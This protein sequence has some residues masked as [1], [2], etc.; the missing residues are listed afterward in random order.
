MVLEA[1]RAEVLG[2]RAWIGIADGALSF[3]EP[4]RRLARIR[5]QEPTGAER[6]AA[7]LRAAARIRIAVRAVALRNA[8]GKTAFEGQ[9][10]LAVTVLEAAR[11]RLRAR[12]RRA[13]R[14]DVLWI[15]SL[16]TARLRL[17]DLTAS[18]GEAA[19]PR[20]VRTR[21]RYAIAPCPSGLSPVGDTTKRRE[22]RAGPILETACFR[23]GTG[24]GA[25][26][27][28]S[29]WDTVGD[30]ACRRREQLAAP[31]IDTA[32]L[33]IRLEAGVW[34]AGDPHALGLA[35]LRDTVIV[36]EQAGMCRPRSSMRLLR[37]RLRTVIFAGHL[38]TNRPEVVDP[39]LDRR[40]AVIDELRFVRGGIGRQAEVTA[41]VL[42]VDR[43]E[44]ELEEVAYT[45][46][47][48]CNEVPNP[49]SGH[50]CIGNFER[51]RDRRGHT[52]K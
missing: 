33:S 6:K 41:G 43:E 12:I 7:R 1:A 25:V 40:T 11:L 38:P 48:I 51:T 10:H 3:G 9:H 28:R 35:T 39:V 32:G 50:P 8:P 26:G 24:F 20:L 21:I 23:A 34:I 2:R 27:P 22:Q 49:V 13:D 15:P 36:W 31:V 45:G 5:E 44:V 16:R 30:E 14:A 19:S 18:V 42:V 47:P 4:S 17:E 52:G 37:R 46:V 29:L